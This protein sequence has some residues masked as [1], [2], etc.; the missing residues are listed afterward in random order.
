MRTIVLI[1]FLIFSTGGVAAHD[2]D[3]IPSTQE[4]EIEVVEQIEIMEAGDLEKPGYGFILGISKH[5]WMTT[6]GPIIS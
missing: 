3:S 2:K 4:N 1:F 5:R 6:S